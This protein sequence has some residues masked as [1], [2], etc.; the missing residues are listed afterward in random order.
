MNNFMGMQLKSENSL[1]VKMNVQMK[2][3]DF[4]IKRGK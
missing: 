1:N 2:I 3:N 4:I